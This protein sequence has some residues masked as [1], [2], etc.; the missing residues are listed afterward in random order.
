MYGPFY[1]DHILSISVSIFVFTLL[2]LY[3][4]FMF[5]LKNFVL[6][7]SEKNS[8]INAS[9]H[10]IRWHNF[11]RLGVWYQLLER[12]YCNIY[13]PITNSIELTSFL[14]NRIIINCLKNY[15][16]LCTICDSSIWRIFS[17]S[18]LRWFST[19]ELINRF[20]WLVFP[21]SHKI[22]KNIFLR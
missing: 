5:L 11:Y 7:S 1:M 15:F 8:F 2:S 12:F 16:I 18:H 22:K 3:S 4:L 19:Y 13:H 10:A 21:S 14:Y 17:W 6:F 20:I 9:N